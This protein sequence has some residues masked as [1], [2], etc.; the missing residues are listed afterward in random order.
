MVSHHQGG[1]SIEMCQF[2]KWINF[3]DLARR[4]SQPGRYRPI[5]ERPIRN[6]KQAVQWL[7]H[8][9]TETSRMFN[10]IIG[11]G[12]CVQVEIGHMLIVR[13]NHVDRGTT[14]FVNDYLIYSITQNSL[15]VMR[16]SV[17]REAYQ[18][19]P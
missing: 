16:D 7:P 1:M 3:M 8:S 17:F 6:L 10:W 9:V 4:L 13:R 5:D 11:L 15:S 18:E 12:F 14:V 2:C 19:L